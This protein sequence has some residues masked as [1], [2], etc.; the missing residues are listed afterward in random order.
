MRKDEPVVAPDEE[1]AA[2][3]ADP[4]SGLSGAQWDAVWVDCGFSSFLVVVFLFGTLA[5]GWILLG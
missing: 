2:E 1:A 3:P 4:Q 5:A